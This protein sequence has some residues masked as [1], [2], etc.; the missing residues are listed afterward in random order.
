MSRDTRVALGSW[1]FGLVVDHPCVP[2]QDMV[3]FLVTQALLLPIDASVGIAVP[4]RGSALY[5]FAVDDPQGGVPPPAG[6]AAAADDMEGDD[7]ALNRSGGYHVA[8]AGLRRASS[9]DTGGLSRGTSSSM[10][11][12]DVTPA[13]APKPQW[14]ARRSVS[15]LKAKRQPRQTW[16]LRKEILMGLLASQYRPSDSGVVK[17]QLRIVLGARFD[18]S[19]A[20]LF[21]R[22]LPEDAAVAASIWDDEQP[23]VV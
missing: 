3:T 5:R 13:E 20:T 2:L 7:S 8:V 6:R 11:T 1:Q 9:A 15:E 21:H 12:P 22:R 18:D 4:D 14:R 17:R 16:A 10:S 19:H 23:A